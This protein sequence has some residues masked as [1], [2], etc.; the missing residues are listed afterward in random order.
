M[1]PDVEN[2]SVYPFFRIIRSRLICVN[3]AGIIEA[4]V[5]RSPISEC[6]P[7]HA[8]LVHVGLLDHTRRQRPCS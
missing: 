2:V 6:S 7:I 8:L 3:M 5:Y 1:E 4:I